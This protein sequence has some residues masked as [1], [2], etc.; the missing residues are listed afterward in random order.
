MQC[1]ILAGGLG[2]RMRGYEP[3]VPK[4]MLLVAGEPF[5]GWQLRWLASEGV[6]SVVFSIG[7]KGEVIEEF[8]GDGHRWGLDVTYVHERD[9]LLG[10][11]GAV[12]FAAEREVLNEKFFLMYGDSYLQVSMQEVDKAFSERGL[13][14]LMTVF[15][16]EGRWDSSNVVFDGER[17]VRYEKGLANPPPDMRYID[18]GLLVLERSTVLDRI[19]GKHPCDLSPFLGRLSEESLLGG[20]EAFNRFYEIGSPEGIRELDLFLR[21]REGNVS[22]PELH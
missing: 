17:V 6:V 20:I 4:S 19:S 12:R 10:T 16:N 11:G 21:S 22:P 3:N 8:V 7:H 18:Y 9:V 5:A 1:L 13:P 2:T 15:E 14:A